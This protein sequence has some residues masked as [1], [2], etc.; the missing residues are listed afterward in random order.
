MPVLTFDQINQLAYRA[1]TGSGANDLQAVPTARSIADAEAEGIRNVGLAYLPTYCEHLRVGKVNGLAN[2]R[3]VYQAGSSVRVDADLGFAHPA[4]LRGLDALV[5]VAEA[6]GVA[7]L[8]IIHSYS[9]GVLGW[10]VDLIARRGLVGLGFANASPSIAPWGGK[11]PLF[12]TNPIA[13]A[14]PR[15]GAGPLV[16]DMATSATARVNVMEAAASG[17]PI[18]PDWAFD[19]EGRPTTDAAAG[20]AGSI[21]P[22][23]GAKGYGL[24][25]IV[26]LLAAGVTGS[27][28]S[29]ETSS[30]TNNDGGP[31]DIGQLFIAINPA[32]LG[33]STWPARL[34]ELTTEIESQG[35]AR[36][37]GD[38]R[39]QA[40]ALAEQSG[41]EVPAE[42]VTLIEKYASP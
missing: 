16:V 21:A 41:V 12:G 18:P 4:F 33:A 42:L 9:A 17:T 35:N 37:P 30:L 2:P 32:K 7:A 40:R 26:E 28:W 19:A 39:R 20:L 1:L 31:P 10:F 34:E 13:L 29:F 8:S 36:L 14:A 5:P 22:V 23:G 6:L 24:A 3:V 15:T 38:R 27:N 25:L 11:A